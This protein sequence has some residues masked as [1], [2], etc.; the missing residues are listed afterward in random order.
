M[1]TLLRIDASSRL[2]GSHS[3][4]MGDHF[5]TQWRQSHPNS[6]VTLR[7]LINS[8]V[9]HISDNTIN[10]FFSPEPLD[11][12]LQQATALSD[13]LIHEL[14]EADTLLITTPMYNFSIP[15]SLKA[16]ID[17]VSRVNHTFSFSETGFAGLINR[18]DVY[19]ITSSGAVFSQ[20]DF[21]AMDFMT[22][23]LDAMLSFLGLVNPTFLAI[24]GSSGFEEALAQ[25]K[26]SCIN[27]IN[28][29]W[30]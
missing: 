16:W 14:K 8:P 27:A 17:Q 7:D 6:K 24:E 10:G 9:P 3:R 12:T 11:A 23:Y 26:Q 5:V 19:V 30:S 25:S 29:Y 22:T 28:N 20:G 21:K 15:S 18:K 2:E 13:E 1:P 4:E